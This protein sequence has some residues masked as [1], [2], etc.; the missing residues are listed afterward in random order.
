MKSIITFALALVFTG[1]LYAQT[2]GPSPAE[3]R[4]RDQIKTLTQRMTAAEAAQVALQS[5][6]TALEEKLKTQEAAYAGL[7]KS[8]TAE[9]DALKAESEKLKAE[10]TDR[11]KQIAETKTELGKANTNVEKASI[12]Y[13]KTEAER[14]RL[15][16]ESLVL[17]RIVS[18]QRLKNSQMY[19]TAKEILDKF[20]KFGFGTALT[21]REQVIGITRARLESYFEDYSSQLSKHRIRLDGTTPASSTPTATKDRPSDGKPAEKKTA[22][23]K[24]D[25]KS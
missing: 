12:Q 13:Q 1:S 24:A 17:K 14:A 2:A 6:K 23:K 5:E 3:Q 21:S 7:V 18:D 10:I 22:E 11:E 19:T 15:A 4:L 25:A 9:K 20:T 8:S 16:N